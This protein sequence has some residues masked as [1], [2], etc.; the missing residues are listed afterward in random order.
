MSFR[1]E[2]SADGALREKLASKTLIT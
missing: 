2:V 1:Y